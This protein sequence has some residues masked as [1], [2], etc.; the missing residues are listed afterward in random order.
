MRIIFLGPPGSGK[1][2]QAQIL[3][4]KIGAPQISSGDLLREAVKNNTPTGKKAKG[5]MDRG[6]LVPDSIVIQLMGERIENEHV[7]IL[8]G[9]PRT[10]NQA[11]KLDEILYQLTIPLDS[12]V[13]IDVPLEELIERLSGRLTCKKC[14]AIYHVQYNPP[15]REGICDQ[16]GGELLQR[17]DDTEAAITQRFEAYTEQTSPLICY[18]QEK[19]LLTTVNGRGTIEEVAAAIET[20]VL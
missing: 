6:E 8:D 19:G 17:S 1:G 16:C 12:V 9:F 11:E 13:N 20:E 3:A 14:N 10:V 18:Y 7:F 15:E 2:T 5:Y 4:Q